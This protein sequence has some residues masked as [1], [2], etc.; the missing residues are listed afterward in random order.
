MIELLIE[1]VFQSIAHL[2]YQGQPRLLAQAA[3]DAGTRP[4]A[5]AEFQAGVITGLLAGLVVA[6]LASRA[7]KTFGK[8]LRFFRPTKWPATKDGP[9]PFEMFLNCLGVL[10]ILVIVAAVALMVLMQNAGS[11]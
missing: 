3:A 2:F 4:V 11:G 1:H 10:L 5:S 7:L 9:T 8:L 6:F